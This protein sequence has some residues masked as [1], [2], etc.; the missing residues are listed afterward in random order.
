MKNKL[1]FSSRCFATINVSSILEFRFWYPSPISN[2]LYRGCAM[3]PAASELG[4]STDTCP[5]WYEGL[6]GLKFR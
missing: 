3:G 2:W 6:K 5:I 4:T 1:P